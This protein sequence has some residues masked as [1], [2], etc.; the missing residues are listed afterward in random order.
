MDSSD[1]SFQC[2]Y[3][4]TFFKILDAV[5]AFHKSNPDCVE[6]LRII[7][8]E[9]NKC[10]AVFIFRI[11]IKGIVNNFDSYEF[12]NLSNFFFYVTSEEGFSLL[13]CVYQSDFV[14]LNECGCYFIATELLGNYNKLL[15]NVSYKDKF[16][17]ISFR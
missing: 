12:E 4:E 9:G 3:D 16:I 14:M 13:K 2:N 17:E 15:R 7:P 11:I 5:F 10:R 1:Y 6:S 8:M